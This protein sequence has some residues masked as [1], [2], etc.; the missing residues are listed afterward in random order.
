MVLTKTL[1]HAKKFYS[2]LKNITYH[3]F[4]RR[5]YTYIR[6]L[7]NSYQLKLFRK[8]KIEI[9][10]STLYYALPPQIVMCFVQCKEKEHKKAYLKK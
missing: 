7:Y 6:F 2:K 5:P 9:G 10:A 4:K 8:E 1:L 3:A